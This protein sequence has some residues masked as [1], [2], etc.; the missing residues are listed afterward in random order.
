MERVADLVR[1]LVRLRL[2]DLDLERV[3][4][5][6]LDLVRDDVTE[7]VLVMVG[8]AAA[9][10][11]SDENAT[12]PTSAASG[13]DTSAPSD[14]AASL[15][16][17]RDSESSIADEPSSESD[18]MDSCSLNTRSLVAPTCGGE[19]RGRKGEGRGKCMLEIVA[20]GALANKRGGNSEMSATRAARV[21][22]TRY[23]PAPP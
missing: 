22:H 17:A 3:L 20:G 8:V 9:V 7:R 11:D 23:A 12:S 1:V 18:D 19:I 4:E 10:P 6:D 5:R 16:P 14:A 15:K 13:A 2:R 21:P